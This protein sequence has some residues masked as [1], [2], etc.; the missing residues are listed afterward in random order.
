MAPETSEGKQG[1]VEMV[2]AAPNPD[3]E[4]QQQEER[5]VT[6][7]QDYSEEEAVTAAKI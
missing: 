2:S 6:A 4:Q 1:E 3:P 7:H 5:D